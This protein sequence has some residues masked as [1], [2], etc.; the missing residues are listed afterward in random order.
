[1]THPDDGRGT[2]IS[3]NERAQPSGEAMLL[4][5]E[6]KNCQGVEVRSINNNSDAQHVAKTGRRDDFAKWREPLGN[7]GLCDSSSSKVFLITNT[8]GCTPRQLFRHP[9]VR[10]SG[11][12]THT[13]WSI[14]LTK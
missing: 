12:Q 11:K 14:Q 1:L 13:L 7:H 6:K 9:S 5:E 2:V 3:N 10:I 8:I 4:S